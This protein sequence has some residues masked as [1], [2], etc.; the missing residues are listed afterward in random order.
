MP[1]NP[2][3]YT[4]ADLDEIRHDTER[5]PYVRLVAGEL[6]KKRRALRIARAVLADAGLWPEFER[7]VK[8][9]K[10]RGS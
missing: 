10:R 4:N 3:R 2:N 7:R 6:L 1:K 9:M 5:Y 8:A